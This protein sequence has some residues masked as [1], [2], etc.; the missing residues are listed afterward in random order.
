MRIYIEKQKQGVIDHEQTCHLTKLRRSMCIITDRLTKV[1]AEGA[2]LLPLACE[3]VIQLWSERAG[4]E[5]SL[6]PMMMIVA[7]AVICHPIEHSRG[8]FPPQ[9]LSD[10][11]TT[12]DDGRTPL[13]HEIALSDC[14]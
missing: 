13:C 11:A 8:D 2:M 3:N 10:N 12:T 6:L 9:R 7:A 1:G 4:I 5:D 14:P